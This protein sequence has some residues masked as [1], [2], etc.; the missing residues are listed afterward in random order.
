MNILKL[1]QS[2]IIHLCFAITF[3]TSGVIVN[4]IQCFFYLTLRP[5]NRRLYRKLNWYFCFTIY[6]QLVFLGD[7]W[8]GSRIIFYVDREDFDKYFGKEHSY[9]VMNHTYEIDWLVGWMICDRLH[10]LGNC[11]AYAKKVVQYIPVLGW[12]WKCSEF[13]FLERSF[14]KDKRVIDTQVTE[15][16]EHPDPMWLLL[17]PEGTRF[18]PT[19]HK[20]SLEFARQKN[21]PELKHHLLPRTKGF[22]ASLPSMKGKVPA[23]YD[24]E[25]CFNEN[26]PYKP[27]IRNMLFGRPVT[28][29]IYMRRIP[30]EDVPQTEREQEDFLREMFV[31]KD[32]LKDSFAKTGDFFAT[33]GISRVEPFELERRINSVINI[34]VWVALICFPMVYYLI[35]LLFSGELLYFSIGASIIGAFYLLL[36]KTIGM[37]EIDKGSS[38]GT[39]T[40]KKVA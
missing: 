11:K 31:R 9:C 21:L 13:V 22:T 6:S 37:S 25:I 19:K 34:V 32:K 17:F 8:S 1:K 39:N 30:L 12:G 35:K 28:A 5:F 2:R 29:H 36:N 3:F 18:T 38:Y 27:T 10:M 23:I 4:L 15:L 40:P 33:S 24:N 20:I 14:D 16:A 7:W 26:D